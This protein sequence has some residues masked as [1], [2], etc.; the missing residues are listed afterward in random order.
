MSGL[1][2]LSFVEL[3]LLLRD[4]GSL[5]LMLALPL[6]VLLIFGISFRV[7]DSA[8]PAI[9]VAIALALNALY[10]VPSSLGT[11]REKGILR[12]L[13]TTP[14]HPA[15]LLAAQLMLHLLVT[16][17]A[18]ML[19]GAGSLALGI[20]PPRHV[21]GWLTAFVLGV[22]AMFAIGCLIAALAPNA[23]TATGIGV[24]LYFPM[25]FLGG[26]TVPREQMPTL[27]ARVGDWTPLGALRQSI[28][29]SWAG[30]PPQPLHL[31]IMA[32]FA[33]IVGVTA[34]KFF[35]WE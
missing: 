25:A 23:R 12:R 27:L 14:M 26:V 29:D 19:L 15:T 2:R 1:A 20:S 18:V 28:A 5:V 34:A 6:F 7:T 31:L 10:M 17:V 32:T 11:Y 9:S 3:K 13:S 4:V 22:A 30:T 24:L 21:A 35:R 8:L 33:V 16:T